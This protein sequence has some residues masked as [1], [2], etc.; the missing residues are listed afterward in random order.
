MKKL[1]VDIDLTLTQISDASY[2]DKLPNYKVIERLKE[3]RE[4]GF[5][6]ILFT[7]RNMRTYDTDISRINK[8]TLPVIL[9]WLEK[10]DVPYD[11]IIMGKPWCGTDGFYI[12][13]RAIRPS[14]FV[15]KSY[16][17]IKAIIDEGIHSFE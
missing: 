3:Y 6:I 15:N 2:E 16:E 12:D 1:I 7:S 10:Y 5:E 13:D 17:E 11:G 4:M 14:E 8:H 9:T